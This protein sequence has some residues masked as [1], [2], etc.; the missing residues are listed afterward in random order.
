MAYRFVVPRTIAQLQHKG[1]HF[2]HCTY[3]GAV[4]WE[5]HGLYQI[6]AIVLLGV[7][8]L[9]VFITTSVTSAVEEH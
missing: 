9:G 1:E 4:G 8:A 2:F 5:A 3:L 6:M 7:T